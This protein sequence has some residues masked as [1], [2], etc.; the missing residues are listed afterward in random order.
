MPM[1]R[2]D[3]VSQGLDPPFLVAVDTAGKI[4]AVEASL[5]RK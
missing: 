1:V 4:V 2:S 5:K 3:L